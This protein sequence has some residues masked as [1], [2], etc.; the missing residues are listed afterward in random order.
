MT[1]TECAAFLHA[2]DDF[3]LLTH[4]RPDGDTLGSAAALCRALRR[5]GKR[6]RLCPNP[7]ITEHFL[8]YVAPYL[9]EGPVGGETV[10]SVDIAEEKLFPKGYEGRA[11]LAIDHHP[12]NTHF[13]G[14]T[15]LQPE[16]AACGQIVLDV[17]EALC[18]AVEPAEADLLYMAL[19]TDCGCFLYGNT[20]AQAHRDAARL[21]EA[22]ADI[23]PLNK[24]LFRS[25]SFARLRLEGLIFASLRSYRDHQLN[26][27]VVTQAMLAESGAT[28]DDCDDLA[29][30]AGKVEG[31]RVAVTVREQADGA[32][33]ASVRTDGSVSATEVCAIFGGGGHKMASGCTVKTDPET[34]A[35]GLLAAVNE[36]W[37]A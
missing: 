13:A 33:H 23:A 19:S 30:L 6:A 27:A 7:E 36:L 3:L 15:L 34:L 31:N 9:G 24:A 32:C 28:E 4:A 14:Q 20:D 17:I 11:E 25:F 16:K 10:V 35:A 1:V 21:I 18:G 2:H 12:T 5:A 26:L 22:G 29:N 37:P 8:P